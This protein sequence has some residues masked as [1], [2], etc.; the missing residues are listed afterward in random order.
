MP[1]KQFGQDLDFSDKGNIQKVYIIA[2]IN[3]FNINLR[4]WHNVTKFLS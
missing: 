2:T 4:V 3:I 1:T